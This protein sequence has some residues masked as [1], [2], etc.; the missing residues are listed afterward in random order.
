MKVKNFTTFKKFTLY[1][2]EKGLRI[3]ISLVKCQ[4][5]NISK[6]NN[7]L[8]KLLSTILHNN[9]KYLFL[10]NST[11]HTLYIHH[12]IRD[13]SLEKPVILKVFKHFFTNIYHHFLGK[14]HQQYNRYAQFHW[15]HMNQSKN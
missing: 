13:N 2:R 5:Y 7:F 11:C 3:K 4:I 1:T 12:Y 6:I 9:N 8:K 10:R 14:W 15:R